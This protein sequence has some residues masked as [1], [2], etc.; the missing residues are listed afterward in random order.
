MHTK[1]DKKIGTNIL[2]LSLSQTVSRSH[3]NNTHSKTFQV[4]KKRWVFF[5]CWAIQD[6]ISTNLRPFI[7]Q[8]WKWEKCMCKQKSER[9][10]FFPYSIFLYMCTYSLC[11]GDR[12]TSSFALALFM[13]FLYIYILPVSHMTL[14]LLLASIWLLHYSV[15]ISENKTFFWPLGNVQ[16]EQGKWK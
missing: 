16:L 12:Y 7:S 2:P 15:R 10:K 11:C 14:L 8:L 6:K 3:T 1:I 9:L 5:H 13:F 4:R